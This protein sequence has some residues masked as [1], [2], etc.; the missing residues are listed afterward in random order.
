MTGA[1]R[2][3]SACER[4]AQVVIFALKRFRLYLSSPEPFK[5][6]TDH[7]ALKDTFSKKDIHGHLTQCLDFLVE[8]EFEIYHCRRD[9]NKAVC[10]LSR[11]FL[12][13]RVMET[14]RS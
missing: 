2:K 10:L 1:E 7:H 13:H 8:Y 3:Y 11:D 4:E 6:I 14:K 12:S 5:L 9:K